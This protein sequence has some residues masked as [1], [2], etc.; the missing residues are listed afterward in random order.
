MIITVTMNP[1]VDKTVEINNFRVGA[2]NRISSL[3]LDAGGKGINVSKTVKALGGSSLAVGILAGGAGHFIK[4][5][6]DQAG[7]ENDFVFVKG[8]TRTNVKVVDRLN[9]TNT[10]INEPGPVVSAEDIGQLERK[11]FSS[12][13]KDSLLV[14]SGSI[15][16]NISAGIYKEWIE[17]AR[18]A[19][20]RVLLDS[21]GE[22]LREGIKAEP[23]LIKPN[24]NELERLMG[25][26]LDSIEDIIGA[27]KNL[28]EAGIKIV[29]VSLGAGGAIFADGNSI[30]HGEGLQV[31]VRSTVG[32]GDAMVA[33]LAIALERGWPFEKAVK[34]SVAAGG[35][36]V[37][38]EG[39]QPPMLSDVMRYEGQVSLSYLK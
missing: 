32:A 14:L 29:A 15:P 10:D 37:A 22:L 34:H 11:V 20:A 21:D 9:H 39:T 35:A 3:R 25:R 8:E 36:N 1:A 19:G 33:A 31:E 30:I 26:R 7:I 4:G 5:Y 17:R 28:I 24:I 6:L 2:V 27:A 18:K 38:T 13:N 16:A 23:Y 12:L